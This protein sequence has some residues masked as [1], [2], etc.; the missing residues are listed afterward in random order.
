MERKMKLPEYTKGEWRVI[1]GVQLAVK[2]I[3]TFANQSAVVSKTNE[4]PNQIADAKLI[5]AAPD[6]LKALVETRKN[7]TEALCNEEPIPT[8]VLVEWCTKVE[9]ALE[10]AGVEF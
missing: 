3:A 10:K 9:S 4:T 6:M 7:I 1:K 5:S 2:Y 8:K